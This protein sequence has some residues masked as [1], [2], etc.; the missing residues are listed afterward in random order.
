MFLLHAVLSFSSGG[1]DGGVGQQCDAIYLCEGGCPS[2]MTNVAPPERSSVYQ[3]SVEGGSTTYDPGQLVTLTMEVTAARIP[4]KEQAGVVVG[5]RNETAKYLGILMYVVDASESRVGEWE[6]PRETPTRFWTPSDAGCG[7][8]AL[9]HAGAELKHY[10]EHFYFRAPPSGAG[11]LIVRA[12]VKQGETNRGAFYWPGVGDPPSWGRAG[13]DLFL[14]EAT[15]VAASPAW[16]RGVAGQACE[17]VCEASG[18]TC[19]EDALVAAGSADAMRA[20]VEVEHLCARPL[21]A[22]CDGPLTSALDLGQALCWFRD[23]ETCP[24]APASLCAELPPIEQG[25]VRLCPCVSTGRRLA[26]DAATAAGAEAARSSVDDLPSRPA[27]CPNSRRASSH[28][29]DCPGLRGLGV[30]VASEAATGPVGTTTGSMA[31]STPRAGW[32]VALL[33]IG[34]AAVVGRHARR[35][36]GALSAALVLATPGEAHNWL[37]SPRS[38]TS[39]RMPTVK[40]CVQRTRTAHPDVNVNRGQPFQIEWTTGHPGSSSYFVL[41]AA[42]DEDKLALHTETLLDAYLYDAPAEATE[43]YLGVEWH[44]QHYG[45]VGSSSLGCSY[46]E[47]VFLQTESKTPVT[48]N[49]TDW[50]ERPAAFACS[51][52]GSATGADQQDETGRA[53]CNTVSTLALYRY[54]DSEKKYDAV[55][56][57]TNDKYPWMEAV[58]KFT[59]YHHHALQFDTARFVFPRHTSRTGR[60]IVHW[61]W[62]GYQD[63]LDVDVLSDAATVP[64][65]SEAIYGQSI[66]GE[67]MLKVD[68]AQYEAGTFN[69]YVGQVSCPSADTCYSPS[70]CIDGAPRRAHQTCHP[71]PPTGEL[72]SAGESREEALQ[73]CFDRCQSAATGVCTAV[74]VV[75][76]EPPPMVR[77]ADDDERNIPWGSG[78]C[79]HECLSNEPNGSAVCYPL[80]YWSAHEP[81]S[82]PWATTTDPRS[83]IFYSTVF[84]RNALWSFDGPTLDEAAPP[85]AQPPWRFA[86]QCISCAD[87]ETNANATV[88]DWSLAETCVMCSRPEVTPY[89]PPSPP[90]PPPCLAS[91]VDVDP[92][93]TVC[94]PPSPPPLPPP[95]PPPCSAYCIDVEPPAGFTPARLSSCALWVT[96]TEDITV[97]AQQHCR[98]RRGEYGDL[99]NDGLCSASCRVC[100]PCSPSPPPPPVPSHPLSPP[101][102]PSASPQTPCVHSCEAETCATDVG[103]GFCKDNYHELTSGLGIAGCLAAAAADAACAGNELNVAWSG[104]L[105]ISYGKG[106]R[107]GRC[108]C[109]TYAG[110]VE[111]GGSSLG[112]NG[113]DRWEAAARFCPL[114]PP[115]PP[116]SPPPLLPD[117]PSPPQAPAIPPS[118]KVGGCYWPGWYGGVYSWW[119][120][121][122]I[123]TSNF[124]HAMLECASRSDC[125]GLSRLSDG[126]YDGKKMSGGVVGVTSCTY[127]WCMSW[128]KVCLPPSPPHPPPRPPSPPAS[129]PH[130][131]GAAPRPPP[132]PPP[133]PSPAPPPPSPSP[134]SPPSPLP[135]TPPSSPPPPPECDR[136][137]DA[138]V[139]DA[140]AAYP[141]EVQLVVGDAVVV[142]RYRVAMGLS[143]SFQLQYTLYAKARCAACSSAG[144]LAVG[145][146]STAGEALGGAVV[147]WL[148]G[149]GSNNF[150][151]KYRVDGAGEWSVRGYTEQVMPVATITPTGVDGLEMTFEAALGIDEWVPPFTTADTHL[152]AFVGSAAQTFE[153]A[154]AATRTVDLLTSLPADGSQP[155]SATSP[156][157]AAPPSAPPPPFA[158][159]GRCGTHGQVSALSGYDCSMQLAEGF[160]FHY[161][162]EDYTLHAFVGCSCEECSSWL[163]L[164]FAAAAGEMVGSV[165]VV[166]TPAG[167]LAMYSLD[168]KQPSQVAELSSAVND[169]VWGG[170]PRG[171]SYALQG[172]YHTMSFTLDLP[173]AGMLASS[174]SYF[175][176]EL[177]AL[178]LI[179]AG[180]AGA[181]TYHGAT[182]GA[183][184]LDLLGRHYSQ[185][186]PPPSPDAPPVPPSAPPP[187]PPPPQAPPALPPV[188]ATPPPPCIDAG[189]SVGNGFF[190]AVAMGTDVVM[191]YHLTPTFLRARLHCGA[192]TG[193]WL[194]LGFAASPGTMP[195]S[196]AVVGWSGGGGGV[197]TYFLGERDPLEVLLL[198]TQGLTDTSVEVSDDGMSVAFTAPLDPSL[199]I[200]ADLSGVD[201]IY[202]RGDSTTGP[203]Y[204]GYGVPQRGGL[205]S[206][207][208][209]LPADL[210]SPPPFP[211]AHP[212]PPL[213]PSPASPPIGQASPSPTPPPLTPSP[214]PSDATVYEVSGGSFTP[215]YY[216]FSPSLAPLM[217]GQTYAFYDAGV[218]T[219]HPFRIGSAWGDASVVG[220]GASSTTGGFDGT[221]GEISFTLPAD[222]SGSLVYWCLYHSVMELAFSIASDASPHPPPP[223]STPLPVP[224]PPSSPP[225]PPPS[226]SPPPPTAPPPPPPTAPPPPPPTAPPP[227]PSPSPSPLL[228]PPMPPPPSFPPAVPAGAPRVPPPPPH[229]PPGPPPPSPSPS[230]LA[231]PLPSPMA[232]APPSPSAPCPSSQPAS[233]LSTPDSPEPHVPPQPPPPQPPPP[234]AATTPP[235]GP[236]IEGD[237]AIS[238]SGLDFDPLPVAGGVL[239]F[240]CTLCGLGACC[241]YH[242]R[243][244]KRLDLTQSTGA[245]PRSAAALAQSNVQVPTA[246]T[247]RRAAPPI[248]PPPTIV[249]VEP[250]SNWAQQATRI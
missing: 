75:P 24:A 34:A 87:A 78:D 232:Q 6:I 116:P 180:G 123:R 95:L 141:C 178:H 142:L 230:P 170:G 50:V 76:L 144:W 192:C 132:H 68:H 212:R 11:N 238:T 244:R 226:P 14:V 62:R 101:P 17:A 143:A 210:M 44:K 138:S 169:L 70:Q 159:A 160:Q 13:G 173:Y 40:P 216:T 200:P 100:D 65:T 120:T 128:T 182:R 237:D 74:N 42:E 49:D 90:P 88:P 233:P 89:N 204:H 235:V 64:N 190:C 91:C 52:L 213:P 243:K 22:S 242:R 171:A 152:F 131:P 161:R 188:A 38:R 199:G 135:P 193:G 222:F 73:R 176:V 105:R 133:S 114:P 97:S 33:F 55:A 9:M 82:D 217:R 234:V 248:A 107:A 156:S 174:A 211:P 117:P 214:S 28:A 249:K 77:F 172:G 10:V 177:G 104:Y 84:N 32:C 162:L 110:C 57:Y 113:F 247:A 53:S 81:N 54:P 103:E 72:N 186:R 119:T 21:M 30:S 2:G 219:N 67:E 98:R 25:D 175:E 79:T 229:L 164:G 80:D 202:A 140:A 51:A 203:S 112:S 145:V 36:V 205:Y 12:L 8:K 94:P 47:D 209:S 250:P 121:P 99:V 154:T 148:S 19:D 198:P 155:V 122:Q 126:Q 246:A 71:I 181:F 15:P 136:A 20:A 109:D 5:A 236:L 201:L 241:M 206:A 130:L 228:P 163:A 196:T 111:V 208:V 134:R 179:F 118:W 41:L 66:D 125:I 197:G 39:S 245:A 37:N 1:G 207:L 27:G 108:L 221:G 189:L 185:P 150:V 48:P 184:T 218:A 124:T 227:S 26:A 60:S 85:P 63:C 168:G 92:P 61:L 195:G 240:A 106:S 23:G 93:C 83:N 115:L 86:D 215:P 151:G 224:P 137:F 18:E 158:P 153:G 46:S 220:D 43:P 127:E 16:R 231:P 146:A 4:S 191:E 31:A 58:Y 35:G 165:A 166:R 102:A 187:P 3:L 149:C 129:P 194:A 45:C 183:V 7:G 167:P 29:A 139:D 147:G 59:H 69:T 225:S 157:P 96:E 56:A 239:L 223:P